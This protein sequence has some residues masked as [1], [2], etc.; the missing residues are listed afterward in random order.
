MRE[1][2]FYERLKEVNDTIGNL[3]DTANSFL[4][5]LDSVRNK[6]WK[7]VSDAAWKSLVSPAED[8]PVQRIGEPPD[9]P[10]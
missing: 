2:D 10:F 9:R 3:H 8:L 4:N 6:L 5:Q 7:L 1:K